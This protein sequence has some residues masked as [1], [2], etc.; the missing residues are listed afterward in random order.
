MIERAGRQCGSQTARRAG[1]FTLIELLVVVSIIA[2]LIGILLPSLGA[3]RQAAR[4]V[5]CKN[6]L[7]QI[8]LSTQMFLDEQKDGRERLLE[9][10]PIEWNGQR[11]TQGV[12]IV[13]GREVSA[14]TT[15]HLWY[16]MVELEEIVGGRGAFGV[17][18][19][20]SALGPNDVLDD[21]ILR[22]RRNNIWHT[23]D[24]NQDGTIEPVADF[25]NQ[26]WFNDSRP[27]DERNQDAGVDGNSSGVAG[28]LLRLIRQ[29]SEV[30]WSMDAV[31]WIPRHNITTRGVASADAEYQ[32][33]SDDGQSNMLF[34]DLRV[35][36]RPRTAYYLARDN[37]GA[38]GPFYNWGHFYPER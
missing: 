30:V 2:L 16:A 5:I 35:E 1:A 15:S 28:Q 22:R 3:A 6:N 29:P 17:F 9:L 21:S 33:N 20:P 24:A 38:P 13:N 7:K 27:N 18:Q 19:C 12:Q 25:V 4:D 36:A 10:Y 11:L 14:R 8:G 31:E 34:G 23:Y 37:Y 26:Y 32:T